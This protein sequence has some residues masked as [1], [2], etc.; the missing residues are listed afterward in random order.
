MDQF[1]E[2]DTVRDEPLVSITFACETKRTAHVHEYRSA[3]GSARTPDPVKTETMT[4]DVHASASVEICVSTDAR[5]TLR[6]IAHHAALDAAQTPA[7]AGTSVQAWRNRRGCDMDPGTPWSA[8][9]PPALSFSV[10]LD[11]KDSVVHVSVT[12]LAAGSKP[13]D[14]FLKLEEWRSP[15]PVPIPGLRLVR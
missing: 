15:D 1:Y 10:L 3:R 2:L 14:R 5:G 4:F 9:G 11:A 7:W 13:T 12:D 8:T 6:R